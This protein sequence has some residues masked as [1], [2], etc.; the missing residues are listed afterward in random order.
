MGA[1]V[2]R[3]L[4]VDPLTALRLLVLSGLVLLTL[5]AGLIGRRL[6][7]SLGAGLVIGVFA[8]AGANPLGPAIALGRHL[9]Q[10]RSLLERT[11]HSAEVQTVHVS[12]D[13][14][15]DLMSRPLLP[16]M[17][18]SADWR[19][20]QNI[21]WSADISSRGLALG[22]MM[23]LLYFLLDPRAGPASLAGTVVTAPC[24]LRSTPLSGLPP[25]SCSRVV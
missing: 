17:Y 6:Y 2:S 16:A 8:L 22:V 15:D 5:A 7:R 21:V 14:A 25:A 1:G 4:G 9:F 12:D 18:L 10:H 20:G 23:L 19:N 13:L 3:A 11:V 24:S